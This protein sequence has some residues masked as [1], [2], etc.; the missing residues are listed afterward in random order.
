MNNIRDTW[1]RIRTL[2]SWKQSAPP[3]IHF[4]SQ[5]NETVRNPKKTVNI[6]NDYFSTIAEKTKGKAR[7]A[8]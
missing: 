7:L 5:D 8:N 3:Y 1:K 2:T 4:L 6:F